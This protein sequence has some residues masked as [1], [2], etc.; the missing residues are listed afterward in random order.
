MRPAPSS[1]ARPGR[2]SAPRGAAA[3]ALALGATALGGYALSCNGSARVGEVESAPGDTPNPS[4]VALFS[5]WPKDQ[6][7]DIT[8]ALTGQT[9]GY[10]SPCGCSRP[11]KGGLERRANFLG[12]LRKKGWTVV[13][14]DLGDIAPGKGVHDQNLLKY[15]TEM[16]ALREMGYAAV[17][18]GEY[19]FATQL[20]DILSSYTLNAEGKPPVVLAA[21]L[22]GAGPPGGKPLGLEE[23]FGAP[24]DKTR[25]MV[26]PFEVV[27]RPNAPAVGVVS[28][29]GPSVA[30]KIIALDKQWDFA[31][32]AA[33]EFASQAVIEKA[34]ADMAKRP[35]K[36]ELLVLLYVGKIEDARRA[37]AAFPAFQVVLCQSDST[38]PP[39]FPEVVNGGKTMIVQVGQKGQ[40]VGVVG[41]FRTPAGLSLHYQ[42]VE[43]TEDYL[44]PPGAAAEKANGV[45]QLL[46][47]YTLKVKKNDYLSQ[48]A[49]MKIQHPA[50][51]RS[52]GANIHYA[53][54][55][56]CQKCHEEVYNVWASSPHAHAY[57]ALEK[58]ATRPSNRQ[59]DGE[60]LQCH[61]VGMGF[62]TGFVSAEK[63]PNLLNNG[64]ENCHG[65]GSAHNAAPEDKSLYASLSPWKISPDDRLPDSATLLEISKLKLIDQPAAVDKLPAGQKAVVNQVYNLCAKCH[66]S[67][68]D[69]KFELYTYWPKVTHSG[70]KKVAG[71]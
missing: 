71:K 28:V 70:L 57:E 65:P 43:M 11:Q 45:L 49:A 26:E 7:P 21:N 9:Y 50:Q 66:D 15:A 14:L 32:N 44:T 56:S 29:V 4:G 25:P 48:Y 16:T 35:A 1:P 55:A 51:V 46:E 12:E 6:T 18:L 63:T 23:Y 2:L 64:C 8:L 31:R 60:C 62:N 42:L 41:A 10:L 17:G 20:T 69:P 37:A 24:T 40:T 30:E 39:A 61:T 34:L 22:L 5:T 68:N 52:A 33:N 53:G 13:G 67:E 3:L 58:L 47:D 54:S 38:M 19:D 36:P 27:A 59:F